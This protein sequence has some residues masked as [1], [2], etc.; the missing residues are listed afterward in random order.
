METTPIHQMHVFI[1]IPWS[2]KQI[3]LW[4]S[5]INRGIFII[6]EDLLAKGVKMENIEKVHFVTRV[7]NVE[8]SIGDNMG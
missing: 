5:C 4:Y 2:H 6:D 1:W 8:V 3:T 7:P